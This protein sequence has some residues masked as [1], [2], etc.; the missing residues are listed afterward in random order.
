[1]ETET[2]C[3]VCGES[4]ATVNDG[5]FCEE[6]AR[7]EGL[8]PCDNCGEWVPEEDLA[9]CDGN[10]YCEECQTARGYEPCEHC[11]VLTND[12]ME[13][14]N[15]YPYC[16]SC[17]EDIFSICDGCGG[18]YYSEDLS[19]HNGC[20]YCEDCSPDCYEHE[21]DPLR[22]NN[23]GNTYHKIG[24]RC[25][26][27]E[28]ETHSCENYEDYEDKGAFGAKEDCS[29]D[30]REFFSDILRGDKGLNEIVKLCKFADENGWE[31]SNN[32]GLHVHFDMR[33]E[34]SDGLKAITLAML[35]TYDVW[36]AFVH[37]NR[38]SNHY[39]HASRIKFDE[40]KNAG[41]FHI[42][43]TCIGTRYEW[44]NLMAYCLHHTFE[45]RLHH[46]TVDATTICNWVRGISLFMDWASA[47]KWD[48]VQL[49]L[50]NKSREEKFEFLC[51]VWKQAGQHDLVEWFASC[52][53]FVVV[54]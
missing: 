53:R 34:S 50:Q 10:E 46:G 37:S 32:C 19:Y 20:L 18:T 5:K 13:G 17:W 44:F 23:T 3:P 14:A 11:G 54:I 29:V 15:G 51:E 45:V 25:F 47:A 43:T 12:S 40:L 8:A 28:V 24:H 7:E 33:D 16:Q 22:F 52:G 49:A 38:H 4:E 30:G 9:D 27:V 2:L 41:D 42:F 21:Y 36:K 48:G 31:V 39:C 26:G 35:S 6:C 1:M